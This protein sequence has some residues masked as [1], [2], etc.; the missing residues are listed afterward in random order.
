MTVV[1][2]REVVLRGWVLFERDIHAIV[3]GQTEAFARCLAAGSLPLWNPFAGFGQPMLANPGAQVLYPWTW[4][5][6]LFRPQDYYDLYALG[7]VALGGLGVLLLGRRLGLSP[8]PGFLSGALFLLS[9]PFLSTVD[10]WQH[11]AGA[12]LVPWALLAGDAA[13]GSPSPRRTVLW[14][15]AVAVQLLSGSLDF[16]ILGAMAQGILGLRHL[17]RGQLRWRVEGGRALA[18]AGAVTVA[19]LLSAAQW[20]PGLEL[21]RH[22]ARSALG[23]DARTLWSLHPLL[24]LQTLAPLLPQDL[25]LTRAARVLLFDGREPLLASLY[26]GLAALPLVLAAILEVR[27]RREVALLLTLGFVAGALALGRHALP[28]FWAL[29]ATPGLGILRFPAKT[30]VLVAL[31]WALLAG[32]G[33]ETRGKATRWSSLVGTAG[34]ALVTALAAAGLGLVWAG[35]PGYAPRWLEPNP[36]GLPLAGLLGPVLRPLL[37]AAALGVLAAVVAAWAALCPTAD[38]RR[39]RV[40]AALAVLDLALAHGA[41]VPAAPRGWF[42]GRP[43]ALDLAMRDGAERLY[44][45]DYAKRRADRKA[46]PTWRPEDPPWVLALPRALRLALA[47]QDYP[48][49]GARWG[50]RGSYDPDVAGLDSHARQSLALLVRWVQEDGPSL[51]RLLRI[52]GVTHVLSRHREGLDPLVLLGAASTAHAGEVFTLRVPRPLPR[53]YAVEGVR[54]AE[55]RA[56]YAL[57]VDPGFDPERE[58]I[59]PGG[60]ERQPQPAFESE[61][62]VRS[63]R[64]DHILLEARLARPGWLVAREGFDPGWRARVDGLDAPVRCANALFLAVPLGEGLHRVELAYRPRSVVLGLLVSALALVASGSVLW[65]CRS[66]GTGVSPDSAAAQERQT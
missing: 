17:G 12:A 22:S 19:V 36:A 50:L 8:L 54:V 6:L 58:V 39:G 20:I 26:L 34:A 51:T 49:T 18:A 14:G 66:G 28:Y 33:L 65:R 46:E 40:A 37:W 48:L 4:L 3:W 29:E 57:L 62:H 56:A 1:P 35:G 21:L 55:G 30:M 15:G 23:E 7:H 24:L 43:A 9:G 11:L 44:S 27:R 38:G 31:A 64:P 2:L 13:L 53:A 52:G 32:L 10:L 60:E 59:L 41:L 16:V 47:G 61:V 45:I 5:S 25:P 42:A 63:A